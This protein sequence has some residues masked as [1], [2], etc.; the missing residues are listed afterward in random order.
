[1]IKKC[2]KR[3]IRTMLL[4]G[5]MITAIACLS[6]FLTASA[7]EDNATVQGSAG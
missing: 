5:L 2:K 4:T 1:M 7:A 3:T 6:V